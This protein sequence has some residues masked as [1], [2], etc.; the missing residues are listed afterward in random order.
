MKRTGGWIDKRKRIRLDIA[1]EF[2]G[3]S[4]I[5]AGVFLRSFYDASILPSIREFQI[6]F[7]PDAGTLDEIFAALGAA[8]GLAAKA[9]ASHFSGRDTFPQFGERLLRAGAYEAEA[10]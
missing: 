10:P 2:S 5:S 6:R 8:T 7:V 9:V 1:R 3:R 4:G